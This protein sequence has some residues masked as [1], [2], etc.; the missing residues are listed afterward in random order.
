LVGPERI[1]RV[2]IRLLDNQ[3][4]HFLTIRLENVRITRIAREVR[5]HGLHEDVAFAYQIFQLTDVDGLPTAVAAGRRLD[6]LPAPLQDRC[7]VEV[8]GC[9]P[10]RS[11]PP[12]ACES[13]EHR[14]RRQ[15]VTPFECA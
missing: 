1:T 15:P 2:E 14:I 10:S 9:G 7:R 8:R 4:V 5:E 13:R 12:A 3:R 11:A 6:R